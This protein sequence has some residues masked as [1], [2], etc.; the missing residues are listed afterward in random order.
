MIKLAL[1][2]EALNKYGSST[3]T[4]SVVEKSFVEVLTSW[5][6]NDSKT[7]LTPQVKNEVHK[8]QYELTLNSKTCFKCEGLGHIDSECPN[9]KVIALIEEDEAME[10]DIGEV[11]ESIM[12]KK[13][14][15]RVLCY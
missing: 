7:I 8:P 14:R 9:Q 15:R 5:N 10:E 6:P 12:R 3:T 11:V 2:V 4:K 1:K 13:M